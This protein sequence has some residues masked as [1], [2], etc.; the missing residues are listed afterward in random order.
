MNVELE[1]WKNGWYGIRLAM[2]PHELDRL[3]Q[4]LHAVKAD[5]E[6]HFHVSSGYKG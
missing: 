4:L 6:Q 1:D 5:P 2:S 3:V